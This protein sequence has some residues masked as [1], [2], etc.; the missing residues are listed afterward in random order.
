M[1]R[2]AEVEGQLYIFWPSSPVHPLSTSFSPLL[3]LRSYAGSP[4][5]RP[6]SQPANFFTVRLAPE[7]GA[8][9]DSASR[10]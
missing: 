8:E 6:R 2:Q 7:T 3:G 4:A 5:A 9:T 10:E 1:K